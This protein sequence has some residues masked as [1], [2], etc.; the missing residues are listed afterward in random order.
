MTTAN[1][2]FKRLPLGAKFTFKEASFRKATKD[3]AFALDTRG[4]GKTD[5]VVPFTRSAAVGYVDNR[6]CN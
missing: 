1:T 5:R 2:T 6:L 3:G 4:R